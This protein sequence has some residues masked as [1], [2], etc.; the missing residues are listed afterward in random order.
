M[1][2]VR[3]RFGATPVLD[4]IDLEVPAGSF[5]GLL[6]PNGAGK[7]TLIRLL[8]NLERAQQGTVEVFGRSP[9]IPAARAPIGLAPQ[10]DN[11]DGSLS[12]TST[13]IFHGT[14]YGMTTSAARQRADE[15]LEQF[16]LTEHAEK[17]ASEMSGGM[18][19]RLL[20]ARALVP[21]PR[22]VIL[23]EPTTSVDADQLDKLWRLIREINA[24]GVTIL[25]TTHENAAAALCDRVG[26]I[27]RGR[28]V[29]TGEVAQLCGQY[30]V[31]SL[32]DLHRLLISAQ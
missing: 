12:A 3:K 4:G 14:L 20:I 26:F 18:R 32:E 27:K 22:I 6:G 1:R 30:G 2:G 9:K 10:Q 5:F 28:I 7:T 8:V 25:M 17:L 11:L 23:D 16:G 21:K 15:L 13:L 19:R 29:A 31:D 24:A